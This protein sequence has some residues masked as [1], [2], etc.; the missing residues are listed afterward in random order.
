MI[1]ELPALAWA[2]ARAALSPAPAPLPTPPAQAPRQHRCPH[3]LLPCCPLAP[4]RWHPQVSEAFNNGSLLGTPGA[5]RLLML[6]PGVALYTETEE[7]FKD[8]VEQVGRSVMIGSLIPVSFQ[9]SFRV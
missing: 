1:P 3:C 9:P 4:R 2:A 8:K 5:P 7:A 6:A